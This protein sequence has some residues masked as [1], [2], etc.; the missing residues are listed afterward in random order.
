MSRVETRTKL[1]LEKVIFIGRTYEEYMDMFLLSEEEL[2]GKKVLDCP[3]GACSFTAVGQSRGLDIT[4]SD[5]AYDHSAED[6]KA[7]GQEDIQHAMAHMDKAKTNY[8]WKYFEDIDQLKE[9]REKALLDCTEDMKKNSERY[10]QVHLP[11]LL[12][13]DNEFDILLSAHFLFT[14]AD[15]LDL[16]F[17]IDT[18]KELLRVTKEEVRI[19]PL[20]DL[21]GNRYEHLG[22]VIEYL[23][24]NGYSVKEISVPYEFQ[25]G[26][27]TMLKVSERH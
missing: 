16:L 10:T 27:N 17:H 21:Q 7:K 22:H 1:D 6:L 4:A 2:K 11:S 24:D 15:R 8:V 9:H 20:V 14:Y 3:S 5:I 18:L 25:K 19:F 13:S 26:A 12:F 23:K